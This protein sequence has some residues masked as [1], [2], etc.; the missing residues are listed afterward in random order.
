MRKIL[1]NY[2]SLLFIA[3]AIFTLFS[4]SAVSAASENQTE[5]IFDD[6]Q[7]LTDSEK[8]E[9]ESLAE[10]LGEET[11][12]A[13]LILTLDG[14]DGKDIEQ[15]VD[16]Y[17]DE[18]APGYDQPHGNTAI[19]AIDMEE[20]DIYLAGFKRAEDALDNATIDY[21]REEITPALSD[22]E[23]F[24]AFSTFMHESD[25]KSVV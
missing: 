9:L 24:E 10:E 21:I 18:E 23:Y 14:T 3:L 7:L 2:S 4:G 22:G 11:E 15:Y 6:A 25:R 19:L 13:L 20:R 8:T 16:D 12:T 5:Y 17:Y 1:R